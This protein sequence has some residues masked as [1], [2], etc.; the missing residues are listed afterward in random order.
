MEN[1]QRTR[2]KESRCGKEACLK[3]RG[4]EQINEEVETVSKQ[5]LGEKQREAG[6]PPEEKIPGH[7]CGNPEIRIAV[8]FPGWSI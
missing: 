4:Q 1:T 8:L 6:I 3:T 2:L 5:K 7:S